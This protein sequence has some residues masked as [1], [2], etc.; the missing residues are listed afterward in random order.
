[1]QAANRERRTWSSIHRWVG[2]WLG[3]WFA[4]VGLTGSILVYEEPLDAWLNPRLLRDGRHGPWLAP[5]EVLARVADDFPR[6]GVERMRLPAAPGEVYRVL[7]LA[8]LRDRI[9]S[10]RIEAT[11]SPVTGALLGQRDAEAHGLSR[12]LL[13]KTLYDFHRNVLLGNAG[14]NI[15]GLAGFLLLGSAVTG[16]LTALPRKRSGWA[17]LVG[18]KLRAGATRVLFDVHRSTGTIVAALLVLATVTGSTLVYI[19]YV[20]E[21]VGFFSRVDPFPVIPWRKAPSRDWPSFEQVVAR[22]RAAYPALAIAEVHVPARPTTGYLFYLRGAD[23]VH[24]LGDTIVWVHPATG[25]LLVERSRRTRTGGESV[26]HWLFPLHTGSAF[27]AG[28]LAAMC[29]AGLAPL[30]LVFTGL[31]V[32][33]RKRRAERFELRRRERLAA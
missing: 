14:S 29:V 10:P 30:V 24:R 7:M 5:H 4:L 20:R 33:L 11:F 8:D 21:I 32:W 27:G 31:W 2:L 23:D 15:V 19:N 28:G 22:V 1:M 18:V 25:E 3:A 26:M 16:V 9:D 17:R 6:A 13:L 12:P